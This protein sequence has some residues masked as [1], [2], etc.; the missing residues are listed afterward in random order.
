MPLIINLRHLEEKGMILRGELPVDEL[1]LN[2]H[3]EMIGV[4]EP[5]RHDLEIQLLGRSLLVRGSLRLVLECRCVRCLKPFK[6]KLELNPWMRHLPL[7]GEERVPAANDCADLTPFVREDML[8]EL[9]RHPL[10][11]PD[12]RGLK[13]TKIGRAKRTG[14]KE[15]SNRSAWAELDKLKLK[16]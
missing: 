4:T 13:K 8:L 5:L 6:R 2:T 11:K 10:C 1:D 12:C 7:D 3:D 14:G 16:I 9:P 15:E